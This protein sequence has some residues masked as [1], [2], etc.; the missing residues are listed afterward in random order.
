MRTAVTPRSSMASDAGNDSAPGLAGLMSSP[1]ATT[2][3][4]FENI[5]AIYAA[6]SRS[7]KI[8]IEAFEKN[9][10]FSLAPPREDYKVD[11]GV[12]VIQM[13]GMMAPKAN[14]LTRVCGAV[15]AQWVTGQI[16]AALADTQVKSIIL[17]IDSTGGTVAGTSELAAATYQAAQKKPLVAY[18]DGMMMSAAYWVGC[19]ANAVYISGP[20]V[21]AGSIGVVTTHRHDAE[22]S[23]GVSEIVAGRYKRI[24][25]SIAPLSAEGAG[26]LQERVNYIYGTFVNAVAAY[27]GVTPEVASQRM[28]E[29]RSFIGQQ[30]IDAGL[31][32][33][34]MPLGHLV[35][36]M[37][38]N[39][40]SFA[41]RRRVVGRRAPPQTG[42]AIAFL[43]NMVNPIRATA[44]LVLTKA[45]QAAS[46]VA[47]AKT[48]NV[49]IVQALK[50]LGFV[51]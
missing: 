42:K 34:I 29:G 50:T 9:I 23:Q 2:I 30:A 37:A 8:D 38:S 18:T 14:L 26:Y 20:T 43:P 24:D 40:S 11:R 27:R 4:S 3:E 10:G 32:D 44:P 12:A 1:W 49:T 21:M 35:G 17:A 33:E 6:H 41:N 47:Y 7:P 39:P 5:Q 22:Q 51:A 45:E 19:A 25:S 28:A 31:V 36:A 48:N 15:S 13:D 16:N 46:A